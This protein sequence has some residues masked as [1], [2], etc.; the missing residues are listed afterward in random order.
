MEEPEKNKKNSI[1]L[2]IYETFVG[3]ESA[4]KR[5]IAR[6]AYRPEDIDDMV[7]ETFLRAYKALGSRE[8]T[9]PKAY[10]F[11]VAKS[12]ALRELNKKANQMTDYLEEARVEESIAQATLEEEI[13]ANQKVDLYCDAIAELPPQCRRV[14]LMRKYQAMSHRAIAKEL[15][16]SVGAVEKQIT[17]GIKRCTAYVE[18][19]E[20]TQN[21]PMAIKSKTVREKTVRE[22]QGGMYE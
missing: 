15:N 20:Q 1:L 2:G 6:F 18:K 21:R 16:V 4:L 3:S 7:Q 22:E 13:E 5:Y 12:V 11:R 14:F 17:L 19:M 8:I 10:L 9:Y